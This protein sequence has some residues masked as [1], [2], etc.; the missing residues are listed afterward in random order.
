MSPAISPARSSTSCASA[1]AHNH[2][3]IDLIERGNGTRRGCNHSESVLRD[4]RCRAFYKRGASS[5]GLPMFLGPSQ[6]QTLTGF[7]FT[8]VKTSTEVL[9]YLLRWVVLKQASRGPKAP[10]YL[11]ESE[12]LACAAMTSWLCRSR[13]RV[14]DQWGVILGESVEAG[15]QIDR[16]QS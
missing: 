9:L 10:N 15:I 12:A 11:R 14:K 4:L 1:F 6:V 2:P 7:E 8:A 3:E 5:W 13:R 16:G